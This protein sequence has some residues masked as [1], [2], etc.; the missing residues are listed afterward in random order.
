MNV[1]RQI[2]DAFS[3]WMDSV[4]STVVTILGWLAAPRLVRLAEQANGTF[5]I[6]AA[7]ETMG[8]GCVIHRPSDVFHGQEVEKRNLTLQLAAP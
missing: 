6:Q 5:T 3:H 4:A 7:A 1:L 8:I 2:A